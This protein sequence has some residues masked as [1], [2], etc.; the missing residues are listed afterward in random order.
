MG[1]VVKGSTGETAVDRIA[2][3]AEAASRPHG[4]GA[5]EAVM[6]PDITE[7]RPQAHWLLDRLPADRLSAVVH[8]LQVKSASTGSSQNQRAK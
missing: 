4:I 6:E 5:G 1:F 3:S 7:Q 8:L 2:F